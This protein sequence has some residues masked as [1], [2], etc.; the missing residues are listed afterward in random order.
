[1][2]SDQAKNCDDKIPRAAVCRCCYYRYHRWQRQWCNDG[3]DDDAFDDVCFHVCVCVC[4]CVLMLWSE[5]RNFL[6]LRSKTFLSRRI[7][8][9]WFH[10]YHSERKGNFC[11][12]R[13]LSLQSNAS[14]EMDWF[15]DQGRFRRSLWCLLSWLYFTRIWWFG[16]NFFYFLFSEDRALFQ[17]I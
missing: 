7:L 11:L 1:M 3:N 8:L 13:L 9:W 10:R 12:L 14:L 5:R 15:Q 2:H 4:V 17:L 6:L 16:K